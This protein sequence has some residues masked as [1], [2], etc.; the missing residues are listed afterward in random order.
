MKYF[1]I[2]LILLSGCAIIDEYHWRQWEKL[3]RLEN[4]VRQDLQ[5]S[6]SDHWNNGD[7]KHNINF[8]L[9]MTGGGAAIYGSMKTDEQYWTGQNIRIWTNAPGLRAW[10][11]NRNGPWEFCIEVGN[12]DSIEKG[13][14]SEKLYDTLTEMFWWMQSY[15]V[16]PKNE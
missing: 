6:A 3:D 9:A 8:V 16:W 5:N 2:L 4:K 10:V 1:V 7:F 11:W 13:Q 14:M 12:D 15:Y